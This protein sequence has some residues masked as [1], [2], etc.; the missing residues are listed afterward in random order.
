MHLKI[1][2]KTIK[3]SGLQS[4]QGELDIYYG[5]ANCFV[6]V[7]PAF[8]NTL[9]DYEKE[10]A[11]RF[12]RRSDYNCYVSAHALL[13]IE[14]SKILKRNANSFIIKETK[15]GKPYIPGAEIPFSLSHDNDVFTFVI[16]GKQQILGIDIEQIKTDFD[17]TNI[18]KE[19]FSIKEQK[20][21][22]SFDSMV[23]QSRTFFELWTRKEALLKAIGI[24]INTDLFKVQVL[25]GE[26]SLDIETMQTNIET[27]MISTIM[28]NNLILSIA[29]SID[30][31]PNLKNLSADPSLVSFTISN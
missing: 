8:Y 9:S 23:D 7:I 14:L 19:Y 24:G 15:N 10:R 5:M 2:C 4:N 3:E 29:S 30:F 13:R 16:G 22:F 17:F 31:T 11:D 21:I 26:N 28:K 1:Y 12:R 18:S 25:E 6:N 27:F 20:L